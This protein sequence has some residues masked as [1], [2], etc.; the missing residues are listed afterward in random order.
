[1]HARTIVHDTD[2][3][4]Q[5]LDAY[6]AVFAALDAAALDVVQYTKVRVQA[7]RIAFGVS[8]YAGA[9]SALRQLVADVERM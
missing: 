5:L 1:M 7:D 3:Q 4:Q 6:H 8:D 9:I 2:E